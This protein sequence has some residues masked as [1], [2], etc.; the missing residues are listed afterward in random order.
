MHTDAVKA[1]VLSL[2]P[3]RSL[4]S[5]SMDGNLCLWRPESMIECERIVTPPPRPPQHPVEGD[6]GAQTL[7]L[8]EEDEEEDRELPPL[9]AAILWGNVLVTSSWDGVVRSYVYSEE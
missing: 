7:T 8:L 3:D 4:A 1:L 6:E 2:T 5:V 9:T